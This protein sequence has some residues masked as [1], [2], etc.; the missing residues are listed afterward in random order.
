M[1]EAPARAW[2][3]EIPREPVAVIRC[4]MSNRG[5]EDDTKVVYMF[6]RNEANRYWGVVLGDDSLYDQTSNKTRIRRFCPI[7]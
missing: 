3:A 1:G 5:V 2:G 4:G 6:E 7:V